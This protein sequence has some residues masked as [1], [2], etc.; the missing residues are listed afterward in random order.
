M[1]GVWV[2]AVPWKRAIVPAAVEYGAD[3]PGLHPDGSRRL[4]K[5]GIFP[6]AAE[7]GDLKPGRDVIEKKEC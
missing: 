1:K 7:D 2:K 5:R 3:I 4:D 6:I